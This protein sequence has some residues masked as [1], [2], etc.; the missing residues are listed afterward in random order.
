MNKTKAE[1]MDTVSRYK[2][3]MLLDYFITFLLTF[4]SIVAV[5]MLS[6][7]N[8]LE[9]D[10]FYLPITLL[11]IAQ[12]MVQDYIF[13]RSLGKK[14]Y[15]IKII[16][17]LQSKRKILRAL[18]I[19]RLL[20]ATYHPLLNKDFDAISNMIEAVTETKIVDEDQ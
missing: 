18:F 16:Y 14:I 8:E 20:E 12:H 4:T 10:F 5:G 11:C 13:H 1:I 6:I 17:K 7:L 15:K 3:S 19:R 2:K 9:A